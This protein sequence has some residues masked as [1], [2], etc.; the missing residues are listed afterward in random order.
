MLTPP[1]QPRWVRS[2]NRGRD[3][4]AYRRMLNHARDAPRMTGVESS[5]SAGASRH[6]AASANVVSGHRLPV[7]LLEEAAEQAGDGPR[8]LRASD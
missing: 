1:V 2:P 8:R 3:I 6:P 7:V 4:V 5:V